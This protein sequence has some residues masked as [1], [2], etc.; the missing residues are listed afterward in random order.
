MRSA[1][2]SSAAG[3]LVEIAGAP[4]GLQREDVGGVS[5]IG[6]GQ[7]AQL[8]DRRARRAVHVGE[9]NA[10]LA[11]DRRSGQRSAAPLSGKKIEGRGR[12]PQRG[13][14]GEDKTGDGDAGDLDMQAPGERDR[15]GATNQR[16][17]P[18]VRRAT[19][20]T[21]DSDS[22]SIAAA[23]A[24]ITIRP[25]S[26]R[27]SERCRLV[28]QRSTGLGSADA[29]PWPGGRI[30]HRGAR[31]AIVEPVGGDPARGRAPDLLDARIGGLNARGE[32]GNGQPRFR[33][34]RGQALRRRKDRQR[35]SAERQD[36]DRAQGP[37]GPASG[38]A[39]GSWSASLTCRR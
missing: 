30:D 33:L 12:H 7:F 17:Q 20:A 1:Q 22:I 9:R 34:R 39:R 19:R 15:A 18:P 11:A 32:F 5:G 26:S 31:R 6:K 29:T 16:R 10:G 28:S 24:A 2:A 13:D 25:A 23:P 37:A 4:V 21:P 3:A 35:R 36:G 38:E 8:R 27:N 14:G